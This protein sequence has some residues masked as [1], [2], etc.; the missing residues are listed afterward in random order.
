MKTITVLFI[1][2]LHGGDIFEQ[3]YPGFVS[4]AEAREYWSAFWGITESDCEAFSFSID[5]SAIE[6]DVKHI[7]VTR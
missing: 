5:K 7:G 1:W 4:Y 3:A 6:F 2:K